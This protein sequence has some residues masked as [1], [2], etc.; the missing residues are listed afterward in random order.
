MLSWHLGLEESPKTGLYK[1]RLKIHGT[2]A[3]TD[4]CLAATT[5]SLSSLSPLRHMFYHISLTDLWDSEEFAFA[6]GRLVEQIWKINK[7]QLVHDVIYLR[8]EL[9]LCVCA[10]HRLWHEH[11]C[12]KATVWLSD[13]RWESRGHSFDNVSVQLIQGIDHVNQDVIHFCAKQAGFLRTMRMI[14]ARHGARQ[15]QVSFTIQP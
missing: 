7:L 8:C 12:F 13:V 15:V 5:G 3:G 6:S 14:S 11:I 1:S 4:P 2:P 10:V 9:I